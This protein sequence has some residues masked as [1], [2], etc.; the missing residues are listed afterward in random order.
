M[1][2]NVDELVRILEAGMNV[3]ATAAFIT[4]HSF[5]EARAGGSSRR[6]SAGAAR[7]SARA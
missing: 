5:G 3:V 4:G 6:V 1:W 7:C 2:P